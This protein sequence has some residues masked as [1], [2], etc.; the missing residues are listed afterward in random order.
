MGTGRYFRLIKATFWRWVGDNTF[1]LGAALAYYTVFSLAPIVLIALAVA[2]LFFDQEAARAGMLREIDNTVGPRVGEAIRS[3]LQYTDDPATG[4][5][6][7]ILGIVIVVFG[8]TSVFAQLQDALNTIWGVERDPSV[9]WFQTVKDRFLSFAVVLAI[10]FLLLVSLVVSAV[11]AAVSHYFDPTSLPGGTYAWQ[12]LNWLVSFGLVAGLFALIF[13]LLPDVEIEWRDVWIG[14]IVTAILFAVGK[15][16]IGLYIGRSS[17]I[18]GYGAAGSLIV[19]LLWVY[20]SSQIVLFG[21]EF[22]YV[23]AQEMGKPLSLKQNTRPLTMEAKERQGLLADRDKRTDPRKLSG[24]SWGVPRM[25]WFR[26]TWERVRSSYWFLPTLMS[27]VVA[28]LAALSVE[29][30]HR[31]EDERVSQLAWI[32]LRGPDGARAVLATIAGSMITVAGVVFSVTIVALSLASSQFGPRI[33]RNFMRDRGNQIVL[34]TFVATYLYCL[35]VLRTVQ[36]NAGSQFVPHVS[37]TIAIVLALASLGVLIYFIHHVAVSVQAPEIVATVGRDLLHLTDRVYPEELGDDPGDE[38]APKPVDSGRASKTV[39]PSP[40]GGY[41]QAIDGDQLMSTACEHDLLLRVAKAPGEF[42]FQGSPLITI[43]SAR[44]VDD[45]IRDGLQD[46]VLIGSCPTPFQDVKFVVNQLVEI[47]VRALS[48][49]INDPF[50]ALTCLDQIGSGLAHLATR[51]FPSTHRVDDEG[52]VRVIAAAVDFEELA[53]AAFD[54]IR[55]SGHRHGKILV[56][57]W[58]IVSVLHDQ[59]KRAADRAALAKHA[60][61]I[62]D[63]A[64]QSLPEPDRTL[65]LAVVDPQSLQTRSE[66]AVSTPKLASHESS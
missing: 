11:L 17:W 52:T 41:I 36:G 55:R 34:G 10:G 45:D 50:T 38:P 27:G 19:I 61:R 22:T 43:E 2:S 35:L 25:N 7:T 8:A 31:L 37:V 5:W 56:R 57:M 65:V 24:V 48:P 30:D 49:G 14:A 23:Y 6:A 32:Y 40:R 3:I 42:I 53:D 33:L 63:T 51:K 12:V 44:P 4:I 9:G 21:A 28:L 1:R 59:A 16:L 46:A 18:S 26:A 29:I 47:A 64:K 58:E 15:N 13:K 62:L 66:I 54:E 39:V 20:Y 60:R